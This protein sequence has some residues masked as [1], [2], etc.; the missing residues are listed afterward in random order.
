MITEKDTNNL[1]HKNLYHV[2]YGFYTAYNLVTQEDKLN[3]NVRLTLLFL[4]FE[5]ILKSRLCL[6]YEVNNIDNFYTKSTKEHNHRIIDIL[7]KNKDIIN[8]FNNIYNDEI[9]TIFLKEFQNNFLVIR[10]GEVSHLFLS[11]EN[12]NK[13]LNFYNLLKEEIENYYSD[14]GSFIGLE[15]FKKYIRKMGNG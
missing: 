6:Y 14:R 11:G 2:S 12:I 4:A 15:G 8:T 10:Y 5:T 1:N 9:F 7:S 13:L 3:Y